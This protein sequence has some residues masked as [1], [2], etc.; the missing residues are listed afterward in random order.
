MPAVQILPAEVGNEAGG[1]R[2]QGLTETAFK[3]QVWGYWVADIAAAFAREAPVAIR[4]LDAAAVFTLEATKLKPQ[5][6]DGQEALRTMFRE[7]ARLTFAKGVV[8]A[9]NALTRMQISRLL[10]ECGLDERVSCGADFAA[11]AEGLR[12]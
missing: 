7:L 8:V 5:G 11:N 10:R 9:N 6:V 4:S 12:V 3:V 1:F 2:F